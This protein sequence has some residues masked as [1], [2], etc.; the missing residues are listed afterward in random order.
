MVKTAVLIVDEVSMSNRVRWNSYAE[1]GEK[2]KLFG[3]MQVILVGDFYQLPPVS[4]EMYGDT[5][6]LRKSN[7]LICC[8]I[9]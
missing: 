7:L 2:I 1:E 6:I 8:Y 5:I 3:N 9:R 4:N